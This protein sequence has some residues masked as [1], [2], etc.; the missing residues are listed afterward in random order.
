MSGKSG[1]HIN[2][3]QF[4]VPYLV[5]YGCTDIDASWVNVECVVGRLEVFSSD[6]EGGTVVIWSLKK[7]S[8]PEI[9]SQSKETTNLIRINHFPIHT[10][11][12]SLTPTGNVLHKYIGYS[13]MDFS[14]SFEV[15]YQ[16][17]F[18]P[19]STQCLR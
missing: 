7:I 13:D 12:L 6:V 18:C 11:Q 15:A 1:N 10:L 3:P 16:L 14:D 17:F 4:I 8:S 19:K 5:V 9:P 2:R